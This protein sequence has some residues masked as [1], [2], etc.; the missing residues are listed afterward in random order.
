MSDRFRELEK[1]AGSRRP[2]IVLMA[3]VSGFESLERPTRHDLLQ[4][5]ELFEPLF[6]IAA[7]QTR[8]LA[9]AA[10]SR[11]PEVP[12]AVARRIVEEPI[13]I[14]APFL[15]HSPALKN[16]AVA[17][18]ARR[19]GADHADVLSHRRDVPSSSEDAPRR[20]GQASAGRNEERAGHEE[21][22]RRTLKHMV[23]GKPAHPPRPAGRLA[24][25]AAER[26]KRF[27]EPAEPLRFTLA[28]ADA[29]TTRFQVA[30]RIMLDISGQSLAEILVALGLG[31]NDTARILHGFFP[32]LCE[33]G[34]DGRTIGEDRVAAI[35]PGTAARRLENLLADGTGRLRHAGQVADAPRRGQ[36]ATGPA[37]KSETAIAPST[38]KRA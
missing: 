14:A 1:P 4:F 27:A 15:A 30:E 20:A 28:L 12:E 38:L 16:E 32:H 36:M 23:A 31:R 37:G 6:R 9:A 29:L 13:E 19:Q 10:L 3:T 17:A 21:V 7:P 8:R 35:E 2:D 24:A 25:G 33:H 5:A 22:L 18:L 26:L 11:C 34:P